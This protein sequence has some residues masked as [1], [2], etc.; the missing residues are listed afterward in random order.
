MHGVP[1]ANDAQ[2]QRAC[3][4]WQSQ[5]HPI[6]QAEILTELK[7]L[8]RSRQPSLAASHMPCIGRSSDFRAVAKRPSHPLCA[9]SDWS[10]KRPVQGARVM[11]FSECFATLLDY[12]GGAVPDSHRVPCSLAAQTAAAKHQCTS[13][14]RNLSRR[15]SAVNSTKKDRSVREHPSLW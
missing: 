6:V 10:L 1:N 12:S 9:F 2:S 11:A 5:W 14:A 4:H 3:A 13:N 8:K 15:T 7:E